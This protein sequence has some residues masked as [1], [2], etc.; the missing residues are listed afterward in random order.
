MATILTCY[1][2]PKP[3]GLCTR[4][5]RAMR[6]LLA[7][8]HTVHYLA[9]APFP[10]DHPRCFFHRFPWPVRHGDTLLFWALFH[11]IAPPMLLGIALR[12][13]VT[14]A[15]GF[16]PTYTAI[17]QPL[18]RLLSIPVVCFLNGDLVF[19]HQFR[20][21]APWLIGLDKIVEGIGVHGLGLVG[22]APHLLDRLVKR[23]SHFSPAFT[24]V[25]P[26]DLPIQAIFLRRKMQRPIQLSLVGTLDAIKNQAF[27]VALIS[28]FDEGDFHLSIFGTGLEYQRLSNLVAELKIEKRVTFRGWVPADRIWPQVDLLLMPSFSEGLPNAVLEAI[29]AGVPVLA[30]DIPAHRWF[31]PIEQLLPLDDPERWRQMLNGILNA[32]QEKLSDLAQRQWDAAAH[33]RFDWDERITETILQG[34]FR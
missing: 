33:L 25:L 27:A 13:K 10:I 17:M 31:L 12:Q 14:H 23:H 20:Q 22:V 6:A 11:L 29:A 30:S 34:Q 2:R 24:S 15:F 4:L 32:S 1:Y 26:N 21:R 8:G 5:F 7:R 9:L 16:S 19:G 3:G 28:S 18:L